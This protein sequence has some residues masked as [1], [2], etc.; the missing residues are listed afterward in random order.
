M[1]KVRYAAVAVLI[2]LVGVGVA[3][4][5]SQYGIGRSVVSGGG[6]E[7]SSDNYSVY[8]VV[9]EAAVGTSE[10][11][12]FLLRAGFLPRAL[13]PTGTC[14]DVN[15]DGN[16]DMGDV[17]LLWYYVGYPGQYEICSEWAGDVNCT[18]GIDM[19]DVLL[20]WYFVGYPGQY[21]LNCCPVK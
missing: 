13:A 4:A 2:V 18:G 19:G 14:G 20:L 3:L 6:G 10:S 15:C 11:D 21:E 1:R 17:L 7:R 8:D 5:A 16:V 9:G 12:H